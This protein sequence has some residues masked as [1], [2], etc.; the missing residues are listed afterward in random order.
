M[1]VKSTNFSDTPFAPKK[2][3]EKHDFLHEWH[4]ILLIKLGNEDKKIVN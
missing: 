2:H 4:V 1:S 3:R